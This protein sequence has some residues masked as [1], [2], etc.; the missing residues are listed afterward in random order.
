[1]MPNPDD[2][3]KELESIVNAAG[4]DITREWEDL[5]CRLLKESKP[6][7]EQHFER[8]P[9]VKA[10]IATGRLI[11]QNEYE[12][13][14]GAEKVGPTLDDYKGLESTLA[15]ACR[16]TANV[17]LRSVSDVNKF[18]DE[19]ALVCSLYEKTDYVSLFIHVKYSKMDVL[20]MSTPS[21]VAVLLDKKDKE[22][23]FMYLYFDATKVQEA[24][25]ERNFHTL[26]KSVQEMVVNM[27]EAQIAPP[28]MKKESPK[29]WNL[30]IAAL[31]EADKDMFA[32]EDDDGSLD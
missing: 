24:E 2:I 4:T 15:G 13:E 28:K 20:A 27:A 12:D 19:K 21:G 5:Q 22:S 26:P 30:L 29:M 16:M 18:L 17:G 8:D 7:T 3:L 1:M 9:Q 32:D 25:V 31:K 6:V 11:S 10:V 23:Q 14:D